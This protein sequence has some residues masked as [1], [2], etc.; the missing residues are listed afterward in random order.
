MVRLIIKSPGE[1]SKF[2]Y[3]D[4]KT[5]TKISRHRALLKAIRHISK[6]K[7]LSL[8]DTYLKVFRKLNILYILTK[9]KSP[10]S[11]KIFKEDRDWIRTK[12]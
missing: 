7:G 5:K 11:S 8:K 10:K 6:K 9:S 3:E 1:L 12:F 4:V 2:G